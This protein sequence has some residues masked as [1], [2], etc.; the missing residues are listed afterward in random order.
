MLKLVKVALFIALS[1]V[2]SDKHALARSFGARL[3]LHGIV[4]ENFESKA[5]VRIP[6]ESP[7]CGVDSREV[8][9]T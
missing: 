5:P 4:D 2:S 6:K 7:F 8:S 1:R 9:I 3:T